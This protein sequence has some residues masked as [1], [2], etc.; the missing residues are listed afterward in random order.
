MMGLP[1]P[2]IPLPGMAELK[3]A[4]S[5][6]V[7]L[8]AAPGTAPPLQLRMLIQVLSTGALTQVWLA[9]WAL[10]APRRPAASRRYSRR[11]LKAHGGFAETECFCKRGWVGF[12]VFMVM[13]FLRVQIFTDL[14]IQKNFARP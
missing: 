5:V 14:K 11:W 12:G 3:V 13:G 4:V 7:V 8:F 10:T 6:V 1:A 9:A 2:P